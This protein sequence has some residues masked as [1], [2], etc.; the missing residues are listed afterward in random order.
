[1]KQKK[2]DDAL[3]D[4]GGFAINIATIPNIEGE[5]ASET[6]SKI[7]SHYCSTGD[8]LYPGVEITPLGRGINE[9]TKV[10]LT[11]FLD[12]LVHEGYCDVDVY[13]EHSR[14]GWTVIDEFLYKYL[15]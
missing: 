15:S 4:G 9:A 3:Q 11:D 12:Y 7:I 14:D 5:K 2:C 6:A 1:M 13:Y 10:A 8:L